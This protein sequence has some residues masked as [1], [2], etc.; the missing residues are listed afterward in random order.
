MSKEELKGF[1][2][3]PEDEASGRVVNIEEAQVMAKAGKISRERIKEDTALLETMG[4]RTESYSR[5]NSIEDGIK[6]LER[7]ADG[8]E[9]RAQ[10]EYNEEQRIK[11]LSDE[12]LRVA[13]QDLDVSRDSTHRL[14]E[15]ISLRLIEKEMEVR[16]I[17]G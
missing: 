3:T 13:F 14:S 8:A 10:F 4:P 1:F 9:G 2:S 15:M 7:D 5:R 17:K 12:E 11:K 6:D 16:G